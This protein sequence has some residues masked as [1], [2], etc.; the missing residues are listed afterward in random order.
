MWI[1]YDEQSWYHEFNCLSCSIFSAEHFIVLK[2]ERTS[3][4]LVIVVLTSIIVYTRSA[5]Y[6]IGSYPNLTTI[7]PEAWPGDTNL[8]IRK[9]KIHRI[10]VD[11]FIS[12]SNLRQLSF[13]NVR[14]KYIEEGAFRGQ[15]KLEKLSVIDNVLLL[16]LPSSLGPPTKSLISITFWATLSSNVIAYPYF[17]AFEKL[18]SLNIGA[19]FL[20]LPEQL[21]VLPKNLTT[22][23]AAHSGVPTFPSVGICAPSL[24][25]IELRDCGMRDFPARSLTGLTEVTRLNLHINR[26][27]SLPDLSFMKHLNT[28]T[29]YDNQLASMPDLYEL[30]LTNLQ[31]ANNPLVCDKALCWIRMWPWM[32]ASTIPRDEPTC[33]GPNATVGMRLMDVD[34]SLMECFKGECLYN[35]SLNLSLTIVKRQA[36]VHRKNYAHNCRFVG[37]FLG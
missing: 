13:S 4:L 6:D 34:P 29:L 35:I 3:F 25:E 27:S 7:P 10:P 21:D 31:L 15:D 2:M 16:V 19:N 12:Y 36:T 33:A 9:I 24:Q 1:I 26:L 28:L 18:R 30:P 37:D 20:N 32:K 22:F 14:L 11:A 8:D 23:L 5:Y 17:E